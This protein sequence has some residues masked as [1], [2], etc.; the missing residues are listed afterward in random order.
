MSHRQLH[1]A[2]SA[3]PQPCMQLTAVTPRRTHRG[4]LRR[5][6][7]YRTISGSSPWPSKHPSST[8]LATFVAGLPWVSTLRYAHSI[9]DMTDEPAAIACSIPQ[10]TDENPEV[11][12]SQQ[13]SELVDPAIGCEAKA[14]IEGIESS[15]ARISTPHTQTSQHFRHDSTS[16]DVLGRTA[17]D[18]QEHPS[19]CSHVTNPHED[20]DLERGE[21]YIP[22]SMLASHAAD[23]VTDQ[24]RTERP[25]APGRFVLASREI[26]EK[27]LKGSVPTVCDPSL[28]DGLRYLA[29]DN[30]DQIYRRYALGCGQRKQHGWFVEEVFNKITTASSRQ[31][32]WW[33]TG[34]F[35]VFL[36]HVI[37]R[38]VHGG[39]RKHFQTMFCMDTAV[40][41]L[42]N[43]GDPSDRWINDTLKNSLG[44]DPLFFDEHLALVYDGTLLNPRAGGCARHILCPRAWHVLAV[45]SDE[46]VMHFSSLETFPATDSVALV[47][48]SFQRTDTDSCKS[49]RSQSEAIIANHRK[50]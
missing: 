10:T 48:V 42:Q 6:S 19:V 30:G 8:R 35:A 15:T 34:Y 14:K 39:H 3:H 37:S 22:P 23:P 46:Q 44:L 47:C 27:E 21:P 1:E 41:L 5:L 50:S 9:S 28:I 7:T 17:D 29:G 26:F 32:V 33:L 43:I 18:S 49:G 16:Y 20:R 38:W 36:Q 25:I 24:P 12:T 40:Y 11:A 31:D 4:A 13:V 2:A 45:L